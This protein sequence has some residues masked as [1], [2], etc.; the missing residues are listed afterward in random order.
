MTA[1]AAANDWPAVEAAPDLRAGEIHVWR[2]ALEPSPAT[3]AEQARCLDA[4]EQARATA[5]RFEQHRRK[6]IACRAAQRAILGS[7]LRCP[8]ERIAL[9]YSPLGKPRL[10]GEAELEFNVTNS[11]TW[12]LVS[13][14]RELP[15]GVDLEWLDR[16]CDH[17]ALA[18]RYFARE[19]RAALAQLA[20]AERRAAFFRCWTRKEAVLKA[21][22]V[23][24]TFPLDRFVV[25]CVPQEPPRIVSIE[26]CPTR[27]AGWTLA[28]FEPAP[29]YQAAL[30]WQTPLT[31]RLECLTWRPTRP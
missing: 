26:G 3:L 27:A 23:G 30:A 28:S 20:P 22:G 5:F 10:A 17:A 2:V 19:E 7:Y 25:T 4:E 29:G 31:Q 21:T 15:H 11:G 13:V 18:E 1:L 14:A 6:F 16:R 9:A 8:P 12:A 24:L